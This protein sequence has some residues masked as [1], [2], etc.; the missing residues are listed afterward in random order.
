MTLP[1][2]IDILRRISFSR[3]GSPVIARFAM[4]VAAT[5]KGAAL[6]PK[7]YPSASQADRLRPGAVGAGTRHP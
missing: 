4:R 2:L 6:I 1:G 3:Y 5:F 7:A